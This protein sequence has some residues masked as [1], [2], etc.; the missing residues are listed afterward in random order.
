MKKNK[1]TSHSYHITQ[2]NG[3]EMP[4]TGKFND[5]YETGEYKCICCNSL[6]FNSATKFNSKSGWPSFY[7][8]ANK[9]C[10]EELVDNSANMIRTE[11]KCKKCSAHLGH[12]FDDGPEPTGKRYCV[13]SA[14]LNFSK[15]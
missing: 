10:I 2:K 15:K 6:L 11:I 1:L 8:K 13:N 9:D 12:I 14:A 4:F 5:H 3:T 7:D